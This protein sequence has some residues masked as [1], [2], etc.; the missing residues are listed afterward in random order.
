M[1]VVSLLP[2]APRCRTRPV[3]DRSTAPPASEALDLDGLVPER[4]LVLVVRAA[5]GGDE[6]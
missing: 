2:S 6:S 3:S 5:A 4:L 1:H